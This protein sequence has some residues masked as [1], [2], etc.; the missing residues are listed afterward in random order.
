MSHVA[1]SPQHTVRPGQWDD[2][3]GKLQVVTKCSPAG[4][5]IADCIARARSRTSTR[6]ASG[7]VVPVTRTSWPLRS[8]P[9]T[10]YN[11]SQSLQLQMSIAGD[12]QIEHSPRKVTVL[13][14]ATSYPKGSIL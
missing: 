12:R 5:Q 10:S 3:T 4:V 2:D 6:A 11:R 9:M 1:L 14:P 8:L 13:T 7:S